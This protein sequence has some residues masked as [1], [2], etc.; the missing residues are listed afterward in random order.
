M[1]LFFFDCSKA[2]NCC[3]KVQYE[4]AGFLE[5]WKLKLHI[6]YCKACKKYTQKNSKLSSL[7]KKASIK[8]CTEEEKKKFKEQIN[9]NI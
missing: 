3:D 9:E 7:I 8:T 2:R 4:E 5:K 1:G 6:I